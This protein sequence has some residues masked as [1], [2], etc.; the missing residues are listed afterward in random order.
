MGSFSEGQAVYVSEEHTVKAQNTCSPP[1]THFGIRRHE[2]LEINTLSGNVYR[3]QLTTCY[4]QHPELR[5]NVSATII[6]I[7]GEWVRFMFVL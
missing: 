5:K 7:S 2:L 6:A 4:T 3:L 1:L